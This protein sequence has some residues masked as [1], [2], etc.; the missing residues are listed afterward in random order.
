[1]FVLQLND[2]SD[3]MGILGNTGGV[4]PSKITGRG[5]VRDNKTVYE[6]Q[7]VSV[8]EDPDQET[9]MVR[10]FMPKA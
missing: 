1:M 6:F 7:T 4:Y 9:D 3:Y 5:I 2:K 10:A 8:C